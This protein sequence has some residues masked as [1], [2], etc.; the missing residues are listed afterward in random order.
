MVEWA[1][2]EKVAERHSGGTKEASKDK[3]TAQP[4]ATPSAEELQALSAKR[5]EELRT[6]TVQKAATTVLEEAEKAC[7]AEPQR[8]QKKLQLV[9][10][11]V[12]E[13]KGLSRIAKEIIDSL[14]SEVLP[15][16]SPLPTPQASL[17]DLLASPET[18]F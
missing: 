16:T 15:A 3:A 4:N 5:L 1:F 2:L 8:G 17:H 18:T 14:Q 9:D 13:T 7:N 6:G 10:E 11:L 12:E